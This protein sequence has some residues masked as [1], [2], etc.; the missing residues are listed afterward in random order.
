[1]GK[2]EH[3]AAEDSLAAENGNV[4]SFSMD[5]GKGMYGLQVCHTWLVG[6]TP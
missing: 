1:M 3:A 4:K 2:T 6:K 5:D